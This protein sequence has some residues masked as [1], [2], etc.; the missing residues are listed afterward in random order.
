MILAYPQ[1]KLTDPLKQK[2]THGTAKM[3]YDLLQVAPRT[4]PEKIPVYYAR[5]SN[6]HP[7]GAGF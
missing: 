6:R 7:V 5:D 1:K 2:D 4:G 3:F